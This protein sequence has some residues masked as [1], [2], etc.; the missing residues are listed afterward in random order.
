MMQL[1]FITEPREGRMA[2]CPWK[3]MSVSTNNTVCQ[4]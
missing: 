1:L 3:N 2:F 4:S